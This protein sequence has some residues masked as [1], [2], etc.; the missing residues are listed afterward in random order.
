ME[1]TRVVEGN[2][3]ERKSQMDTMTRSMTELD[4]NVRTIAQAR[5][6]HAQ[7]ELTKDIGRNPVRCQQAA[8]NPQCLKH[9]TSRTNLENQAKLPL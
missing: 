9:R 7:Q 5:V 8:N 6:P 4:E 3:A 1:L 2:D